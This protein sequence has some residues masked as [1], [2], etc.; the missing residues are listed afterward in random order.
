MGGLCA[1]GAAWRPSTTAAALVL[2]GVVGL[3]VA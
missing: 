2:A 1:L 3:C